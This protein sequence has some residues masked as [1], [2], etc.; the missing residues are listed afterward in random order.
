MSSNKKI[1]TAAIIG[2]GRIGSGFDAPGAKRALV[3]WYVK[4]WAARREEAAPSPGRCAQCGAPA[5]QQVCR[6]CI[7]RAAIMSPSHP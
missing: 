2:A 3:T 4:Q 6:A 5:S 1:Y 7:M